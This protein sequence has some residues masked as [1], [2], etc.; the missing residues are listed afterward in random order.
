MQLLVLILKKADL[1]EKL[2]KELA[3]AGIC[4]GTILEGA[5]MASELVNMDDVP[6]FGMLR[7]LLA[8]EGKVPSKV[9]L[10]VL[11]DEQVINTRSA[12]KAVVGDLNEPN[13]GIMFAIPIT[14]V[15][16]LGE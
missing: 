6:L 1:M 8:D 3:Q 14:Y 5:G 13:T 9:M 16:G 2:I 12:I 7:A 15:E 11:K 4:G 10:F